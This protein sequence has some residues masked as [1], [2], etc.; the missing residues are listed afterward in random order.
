[1]KLLGIHD[2]GSI[3]KLIKAK[4]IVN[5]PDVINKVN[6]TSYFTVLVKN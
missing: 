1:M 4:T 2:F 3:D 6:S 5:A